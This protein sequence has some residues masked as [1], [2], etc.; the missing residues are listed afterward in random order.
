MGQEVDHKLGDAYAGMNATTGTIQA[1]AAAMERQSAMANHHT[2]Y[3]DDS[4]RSRPP[5]FV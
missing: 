2:G 5:S 1:M 3:F 4:H